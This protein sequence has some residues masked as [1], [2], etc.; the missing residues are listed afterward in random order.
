MGEAPS[1]Q[2]AAQPR[3]QARRRAACGAALDPPCFHAQVHTPE[4]VLE[5]FSKMKEDGR[6]KYYI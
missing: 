2:H 3:L 1:D 4:Q 6:L 5:I